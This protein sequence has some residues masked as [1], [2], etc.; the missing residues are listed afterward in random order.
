MS[1]RIL[2]IDD[3]TNIRRM[4]RM[5]LE[6]DG[7][8]VEDAEDGAKGL[9]LFGDGE[10]F[11]AVLLDQKMPGMDGISTLRQIRERAPAARV[12]MITAFGTIELAVDAM[13]LGATDF[14][15]KPTT[16]DSLRGAL[17]AAL[18]K[19]APAPQTRRKPAPSTAP[20]ELPPV[21]VWTVNGFF[22]RA[23]AVPES[24]PAGEHLFE[25]R[26][27]ARGPQGEVVVAVDPKEVARVAKIVGHELKANGAFW[28]QRAERAIVNHFFREAAPPTGNRLVV[29]HISDDAIVMARI[30]TKD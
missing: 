21:E 22:I 23:R 16:P 24:L 29:N 9:A 5:T 28:R 25:I 30:W 14:L 2:I 13:K 17:A 3:E 20:I 6:S 10:R 12:I 4:M 26:H 11:D 27:A 19:T 18:S 15:R 8:E 1:R 7:Y